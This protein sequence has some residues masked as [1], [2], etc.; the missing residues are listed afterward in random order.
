MSYILEALKKSESERRAATLPGLTREASFM[1]APRGHAA[2]SHVVLVASAG[3][4]LTGLVLGSW[5]P[6]QPLPAAVAHPASAATAPRADRATPAPSGLVARLP[7]GSAVATPSSP[8]APAPTP[9][10]APTP[11]LA[12]VAPLP[13]AAAS[14]QAAPQV[15]PQVVPQVTAL[16]PPAPRPPSAK[17]AGV[18][19]A[20]EVSRAAVAPRQDGPV[21]GAQATGP[22]S[23]PVAA[24]QVRPALRAPAPKL[25]EPPAPPSAPTEA[26]PAG[27]IVTYQELPADIRGAL[28]AV[29]FGGYAGV[30][31]A[32]MPVAFI[33]ARLVKQG[34]ELSPGVRLERVG[35]DGVVLGYRGHRFRP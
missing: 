35:A 5:R 4:L 18:G 6:W 21:S 8:G 19:P 2:R 33:N 13:P 34:E 27:H 22:E 23:R 12:G 1:V 31:E 11:A 16:A 32:G 9:I 17:P 26:V 15:V 25:P 10:P 20:A 30:D 29:T 14:D 24:A 3:M 28:P 7:A